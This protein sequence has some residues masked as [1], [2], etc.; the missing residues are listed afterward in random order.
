[1]EVEKPP[2][3]GRVQL[4]RASTNSLEVS[5][6]PVQNAE[7]YLIQIQKYDAPVPKEVAPAPVPV[8]QV[9]GLPTVRPIMTPIPTSKPIMS[10]VPG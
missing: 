4:V 3:P 2:A 6:T 1:M 5:W 7:G 9:T 10:A 8:P